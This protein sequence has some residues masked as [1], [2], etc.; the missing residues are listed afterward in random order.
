MNKPNEITFTLGA[1]VKDR[2]VTPRT[3]GLSMFNEFN[4]EVEAFLAGS[5]RRVPMDDVQLEIKDGSYKLVLALPAIL[6]AAVEPDLKKL[7]RED[8]LGEIDPK[9]AEIVKQWQKRARSVP[10][11]RVEIDSPSADFRPVRITNET[12]F[13]APDEDD[14]VAVEK[15]VVG[16]VVDMGGTTAANVHLIN[17]ETGRRIVAGSSEG[18]LREQKQNF[19]YRKVQVQIAA[20]ENMKTGEL[21]DIEL[22]S[23]VGLGPSYDEAELETAIEK[24]T[25]AWAGVP[26]TAEWMREMRGTADE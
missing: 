11:F 17:E 2:E 13:H 8:V 12:E 26:N 7:S 19:L 6:L 24:G 1:R 18:F 10:E 15:Y 25:R 16:T 3:I 20:R 21:K 22:I 9:R 23:F 4:E 5:Q 14:W